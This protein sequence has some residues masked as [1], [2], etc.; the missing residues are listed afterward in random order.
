MMFYINPLYYHILLIF[1]TIAFA[2][3]KVYNINDKF[4]ILIWLFLFC[5]LTLNFHFLQIINPIYV[6]ESLAE[7]VGVSVKQFFKYEHIRNS[8][9][10]G[11]CFIFDTPQ[12][13]VDKVLTP[14]PNNIIP[15]DDNDGFK[16]NLYYTRDDILKCINIRY[17][18]EFIFFLPMTFFIWLFDSFGLT[19]ILFDFFILIILMSIFFLIK[20]NS[21]SKTNYDDNNYQKS[22]FISFYFFIL[23]FFGFSYQFGYHFRTLFANL[24]GCLALTLMWSNKKKSGFTVSLLSIFSHNSMVI[25]LPFFFC[26]IKSKYR[27]LYAMISIITFSIIIYLLLNFSVF[28]LTKS[29]FYVGKNID[30]YYLIIFLLISLFMIVT[31]LLK[32]RKIFDV[33]TSVVFLSAF[34][35]LSLYPIFKSGSLERIA[36]VMLMVIFLFG[37]IWIEEK[38]I[39]NRVYQRIVIVLVSIPALLYYY[40]GYFFRDLIINL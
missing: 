39:F 1:V 19:I 8:W 14:D 31:N 22:S 40:Q 25:F 27:I 2:F 10:S 21:K 15:F 30:E 4:K 11:L 23:C 16:S 13:N 35:F 28:K 20:D 26:F 32:K 18:F 3:P 17:F 5:I 37:N 34:T 33:Y 36:F 9:Y 6:Y 12:L 38:P 7:Y 29:N 24:L